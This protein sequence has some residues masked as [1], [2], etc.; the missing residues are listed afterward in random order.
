MEVSLAGYSH[1]NNSNNKKD[2]NSQGALTPVVVKTS[3]MLHWKAQIRCVL[4]F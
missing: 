2:S 3:N 4:L 1:D